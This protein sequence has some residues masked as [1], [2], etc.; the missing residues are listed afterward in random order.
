MAVNKAAFA[1]LR[2]DPVE[3]GGKRARVKKWRKGWV[4]GGTLIHGKQPQTNNTRDRRDDNNLHCR[5]IRSRV[6]IVVLASLHP[7][8]SQTWV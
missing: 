8:H 2:L 6:T 1:C 3:L 7:T 4:L 5:P